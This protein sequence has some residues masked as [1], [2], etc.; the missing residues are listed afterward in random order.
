MEYPQNIKDKLGRNY[1]TKLSN[2]RTMIRKFWGD[3]KKIK[4]I[5]NLIGDPN[6]PSQ[7]YVDVFDRSD[8]IIA[9][10]SSYFGT[11]LKIDGFVGFGNSRQHIEFPILKEKLFDW[12]KKI[13][14]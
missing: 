14:K 4:I 2:R 12:Q 1:I 6:K 8:K 7:V 11:E 5:Y 3:T 9:S 10:Y 13:K